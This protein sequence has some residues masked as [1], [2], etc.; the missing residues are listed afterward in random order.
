MPLNEYP[1]DIIDEVYMVFLEYFSEHPLME[2]IRAR[3]L[4]RHELEQLVIQYA[5]ILNGEERRENTNDS[6]EDESSG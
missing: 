5:E 3:N 1:V 4:T 2:H 6:M